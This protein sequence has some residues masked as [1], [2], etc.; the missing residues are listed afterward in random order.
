MAKRTRT[1]LMCTAAFGLALVAGLAPTAF[2][3][4]VDPYEFSDNFALDL[5]KQRISEKA[6]YPLWKFAH[7][8]EGGADTVILGD[9]RA[10]ALRDKYWHEL[11]LEHAYNFAYGGATIHEIYETFLHVRQDPELKRLIVG[12]Q[13]RSFDPDHKGGMNRVPEA[14][15]LTE[16]PFDY[17]TSWFVARVGWRN[18]A[19][20]YPETINGLTNLMPRLT[21]TARADGPTY[22]AE[23]SLGKLLGPDACYGCELPDV[24]GQAIFVAPDKGPNLGLGRGSVDWAAYWPAV[25]IVR[26]LPS[27]FERQVLKNG[28][29]DWRSFEFSEDLWGRLVEIAD[30]SRTSGVELLFVIPP[31]IPEMQARLAEFGHAAENHQLRVRLAELAPVVDLDFENPL[32]RDIANFSDAYHFSAPVARGI[33]G[34]VAQLISSEPETVALARKRRGDLICPVRPDDTTHVF[35]DGIVEMKEGAG[36]RVWSWAND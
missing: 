1:G 34:E 33:V 20:R 31:T 29:S 6:H 30:W 18:L 4:V 14:A 5:D 7:Y 21:R 27:K 10:R 9:S 32:T 23:T 26:D 25:S 16:V 19:A 36:C 2:N 24:S 35:N 15:A 17:Y 12:I 11:G 28:R 3:A 13:L 22:P 8:P